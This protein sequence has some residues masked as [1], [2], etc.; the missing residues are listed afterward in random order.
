MDFNYVLVLVFLC[1]IVKKQESRCSFL[2]K[3]GLHRVGMWTCECTCG[4]SLDSFDYSRFFL[5]VIFF[6]LRLEE[7]WKQFHK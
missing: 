6:F 5:I 1:K 3:R 4:D 7:S 2:S